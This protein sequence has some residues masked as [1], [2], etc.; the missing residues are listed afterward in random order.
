MDTDKRPERK[1]R[2]I[3]L[4]AIRAKVECLGYG[5]LS[6]ADLSSSDIHF[7]PMTLEKDH[8]PQYFEIYKGDIQ[9][10]RDGYV[11][12]SWPRFKPDPWENARNLQFFLDKFV[13]HP[14]LPQNDRYPIGPRYRD[15]GD[16]PNFGL[17]LESH[18]PRWQV[19]TAWDMPDHRP[20]M[21]CMVIHATEGD[22]RLLRG[23]LL[24]IIDIIRGRLS[25]KATRASVNAPILLFSFM[26]S[27]ARM[28]EANMDSEG[29]VVRATRLYD[30]KEEE[31]VDFSLSRFFARWWMGHPADMSTS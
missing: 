4:A 27:C 14:V 12:N 28:L 20:H 11:S 19:Q 31:D 30:F 2:R 6:A 25:H 7:G 21:K 26:G 15:Y 16:F 17:L 5:H 22:E 3:K 24:T 1:A 10:P 23:E 9:M 8:L 29:L 18:A 13:S